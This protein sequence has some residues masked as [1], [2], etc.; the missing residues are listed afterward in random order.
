M[1][2]PAYDRKDAPTLYIY[3]IWKLIIN[4]CEIVDSLPA[5][6][7]NNIGGKLVDYSI[8]AYKKACLANSIYVVK[9]ISQKRFDERKEHLSNAL[10]YVNVVGT[11]FDVYINLVKKVDGYSIDKKEIDRR[12]EIKIE[13]L[14]RQASNLIAGEFSN[15]DALI[16]EI[17]EIAK[18]DKK[19]AKERFK[20]QTDKIL[21]IEQLIGENILSI[22]KLIV[23]TKKSDEKRRDYIKYEYTYKDLCERLDKLIEVYTK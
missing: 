9:G 18:K 21:K 17:I 7:R 11:L 6:Y 20:K 1:A 10:N 13:R 23:A 15:N 4:I 22:T 3:E 14:K 2:I 8:E 12:A 19:K 5:K 16:K